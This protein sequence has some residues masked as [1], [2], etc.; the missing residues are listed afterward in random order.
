MARAG[1]EEA[2]LGRAF[3][4]TGH[5]ADVACLLLD[6]MTG[7][8]VGV[9]I[10]RAWRDQEGRKTRTDKLAHSG[11]DRSTGM[12]ALTGGFG[13]I[14]RGHHFTQ[15][16]RVIV[17]GTHAHAGSMCRCHR[18]HHG[19]REDGKQGDYTCNHA[20]KDR[21]DSRECPL[22]WMTQL[23]QTVVSAESRSKSC[24][25]WGWKP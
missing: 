17:A 1:S 20:A 7:S 13:H 21:Q 14:G 18:R 8:P 24:H 19:D 15:M 5:A 16:R 25:D 9:L 6:A 2:E 22:P 4:Q 3:V 11:I 23:G 12:F 10:V